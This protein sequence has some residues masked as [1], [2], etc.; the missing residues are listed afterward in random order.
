[1]TI[2]FNPV[3]Y[4]P[5]H[6]DL[7]YVVSDPKASDP[8]TYPNYK[9][10]ADIYVGG[11]FVSRLKRF[12][13][14]ANNYG[15]F[16]VA[17]IVRDYVGMAFNLAS[18]V[19]IAMQAGASFFSIDVQLKFGEEYGATTTYNILTDSVRTFYNYYLRLPQGSNAPLA[20]FTD[21]VATNGFKTLTGLSTLKAQV[22]T[23]FLFINYFATSTTP[24]TFSVTGNGTYSTT[25]T[26]AAA[27]DL[28]VL[29]IGPAFINSLRANTINSTLD[30]YTVTV[31]T[32]TFRVN[33][34]CEAM[35]ETYPIHFLH[36]YGGFETAIFHKISR[37]AV[38]VD[39]KSFGTLPY[40]VASDGTVNYRNGLFTYYEADYNYSTTYNHTITLNTDILTD[41]EYVWLE[42]L[43]V[44]PLVYV[45]M[46]GY[47]Y[48]V[49]ITN[50]DYEIRK[51]I[52]E[53][54]LSNLTITLDLGRTF[55][56]QYR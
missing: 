35:F 9:Y 32:E 20:L 38:K 33:L 55:N 41:K 8:V 39:K 37:Q 23:D 42:D 13:D 3:A 21:K 1:M 44:S 53:G 29:N 30:Y 28:L 54:D 48:P 5:V 56:S 19:I 24:I 18:G 15:V 31:G 50:T 12:P 27:N 6:F 17:A 25:L 52:N 4:A 46:A 26:P 43:I 36:Q 51:A 7:F 16:N 14:P 40:K 45:Q 34:F 47:F 22:S 10:V 2:K 11:V 49:K